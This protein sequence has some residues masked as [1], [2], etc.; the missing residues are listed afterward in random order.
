MELAASV[1]HAQLG[2]FASFDASQS[3]IALANAV[4]EFTNG[5]SP[6]PR[7]VLRLI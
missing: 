6:R 1:E 4:S 3:L 5:T 7:A 2:Y